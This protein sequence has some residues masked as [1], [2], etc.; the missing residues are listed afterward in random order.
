MSLKHFNIYFYFWVANGLQNLNFRNAIAIS[1]SSSYFKLD[2]VS[3]PFRFRSV[4]VRKSNHSLFK[5]FN[6]LIFNATDFGK[7]FALSLKSVEIITWVRS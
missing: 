1:L 7:S 2:R 4:I 5:I 3:N 6:M